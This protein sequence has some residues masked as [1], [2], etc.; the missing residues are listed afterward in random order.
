MEVPN[1]DKRIVKAVD[2]AMKWFEEN[3]VRCITYRRDNIDGKWEAHLEENPK[4][5]TPFWARYYDLETCQPFVCDRDGIPRRKLEE[6]GDERRNG[7]SWYNDRPS[8][9]F[10]IYEAWKSQTPR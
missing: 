8:Y 7:Y 10:P 1:P 5:D 2:G 3:R 4:D 6:I 9:L